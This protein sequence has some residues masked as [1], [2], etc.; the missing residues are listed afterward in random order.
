MTLGASAAN[1]LPILLRGIGIATFMLLPAWG[2]MFSLRPTEMPWFGLADLTLTSLTVAILLYWVTRLKKKIQLSVVAPFVVLFILIGYDVLIY[3]H[4]SLKAELRLIGMLD[5]YK[6]ILRLILWFSI[7]AFPFLVWMFR[8]RIVL[9]SKA[10][11]TLFGILFIVLVAQFIYSKGAANSSKNNPRAN[12]SFV[13][14]VVII[15]DELDSELLDAKLDQFP[16]FN[17]LEQSAAVSGRVYPPSNYTHISVPA[18][19]LGKPLIGS[20]LIGKSILVTRK[21]DSRN[22]R[23]PSKDDLLSNAV[24]N[25]SMVSLVGWHLPYC[26]TFTTI[27][28]CIDDAQFGVPGKNLS[29][30]EWLY[31]KN[32]LLLRYR[33]HRTKEKFNDVNA[34]SEAFFKDSRNFKLNNI[35]DILGTLEARLY[36]DVGS[37]N[38]DLIFAHLPCPHLPRLDGQLTQGMINDYY[39]N[40]QQCDKILDTVI[41]TL[42]RSKDQPWR[43]IVTSDHWFRPG[44]WIRNKKPGDYPQIPRKVPFYLLAN[45]YKGTTLRIGGGTNLGL[46]QILTSLKTPNLD[47]GNISSE[48]YKYDQEDVFLDKF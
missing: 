25:G 39:D 46:P 11:S 12:S 14:T 5:N 1:S 47:V 16:A 10:T 29:T 28:R 30:I 41:N 31:G 44:D 32:S 19:L 34:Y 38:Y 18:M 45:D 42:R 17:H 27:S 6:D 7:L 26:A 48:I 20:E 35:T 4:D 2:A 3:L 15:F 8:T 40:L 13:K 23:L 37:S 43:L 36:E 24:E 21:N 33:G 22:E 9:T